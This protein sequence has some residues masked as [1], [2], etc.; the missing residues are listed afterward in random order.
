MMKEQQLGTSEYILKQFWN[1]AYAIDR[2][3]FINLFF[4]STD[5]IRPSHHIYSSLAFSVPC[6]PQVTPGSINAAISVL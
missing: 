2:Q 6:A 3:D 5:Q 4:L 1:P